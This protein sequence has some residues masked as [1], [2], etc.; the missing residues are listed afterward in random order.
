MAI[1]MRGDSS[2]V[3]GLVRQASSGDSDSWAEL[4]NRYRQRLR[5]MV[6]FRLDPRLQ[7]RLDA[8]DVVQDVCLT[9]WEH[10]GS[11]V[12]QPETPFFLWLRAVAGHKLADLHRHHLATKAWDAR[13]EVS[14]YPGPLSGTSSAAL[15]AQLLGHLTR[16]SEAA[17]R[18]ERKVQLQNALNGMDPVDREVLALRHFE[19]LT[20][21]EA[22][23]VL[24]IKPKA[25]GMRYVRALRRLKEIL[26]SLGGCEE[27]RP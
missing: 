17:I 20:V 14:F 22:A 26:A 5:R 7:A 18:A 23:A 3:E 25:A 16:P 27:E 1:A 10:L 15:A 9:A 13:R 12:K 2:D 11:Y 4:M 19:Q 21:A 24:G 6:S 8:S